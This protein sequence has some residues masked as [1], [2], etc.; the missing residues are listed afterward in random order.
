M[1]PDQSLPK[2]I[3]HSSVFETMVLQQQIMLALLTMK[4]NIKIHAQGP[5][6][7]FFLFHLNWLP[8]VGFQTSSPYPS[9]T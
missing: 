3:Q 8:P 9:A 4:L 2:Q 1:W 7:E 5:D 6:Q